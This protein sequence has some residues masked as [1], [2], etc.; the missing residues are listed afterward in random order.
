MGTPVDELSNPLQESFQ[1]DQSSGVTSSGEA[2]R[3]RSHSRPPREK[4]KKVGFTGGTEWSGTSSRPLSSPPLSPESTS[5][6]L[7]G[8]S[9]PTAIHSPA[10]SRDLEQLE[11]DSESHLPELSR[12]QTEQ[13]YRVFR[14]NPPVA[15]PK[16]AIRRTGSKK[17]FPLD[18]TQLDGAGDDDQ[19]S[20]RRRRQEEAFERGK[21]LERDER[22]HPTSR[23]VSPDREDQNGSYDRHHSP[24]TDDNL[25]QDFHSESP[26]DSEDEG[27]EMRPLHRSRKFHVPEAIKLV[28]RH[29]GDHGYHH[30]RPSPG[31]RSG[32]VTPT[33]EQ[34][35]TE[36]YRPRPEQYRG[37]VLSTLLK[38]YNQPHSRSHSRRS[39]ADLTSNNESPNDT[40]HHSPSDSGTI[41]P[42][43]GWRR[44]VFRHREASSSSLARLIGSSASLG[45]PIISE[46]GEQVTQRMN[47]R[48]DQEKS[49]TLSHRVRKAGQKTGLDRFSRPRLEDEI[50]I[51]VHIAE[52]LVRQRYL[53]KL[54]QALMQYGAPTH[55]LEEYMR[56][57]ARVLQVDAQFLY[58]PGAM[59]MSFDD[60]DTHT[61]EVKLVKVVQGLDFGKLR[62]VHEV[63]KEVV[64]VAIKPYVDGN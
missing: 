27:L 38:L 58:I 51:T 35:F 50:R 6:I 53:M 9:T 14:Q 62:D 47:D 61:T 33:E 34:Q 19:R 44:P 42:L 41:T 13:I 23:Q 40:P 43:S 11:E 32:A 49:H 57:S 60:A 28:R 5:P 59:I 21:Q 64:S 30:K 54:C 20:H 46:L 10:D 25:L 31:L 7:S 45:T 63:Y 52:T 12:K 48:R 4:K 56:M 39:S 22:S 26:S 17:S 37:G 15:R 29:K 1:H 24:R 55:R 36:D 8:V 18:G 16:P 3:S 2:S